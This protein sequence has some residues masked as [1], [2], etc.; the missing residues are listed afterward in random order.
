M[1]GLILAFL[2]VYRVWVYGDSDSADGRQQLS[3]QKRQ[4][5]F[6]AADGTLA[7]RTHSTGGDED[8]DCAYGA[9]CHQANELL[10][11]NTTN[12]V[13]SELTWD[14]DGQQTAM[15]VRWAPPNPLL[16]QRRVD[17]NADNGR[18]RSKAMDDRRAS[19]SATSAASTPLPPS[20]R[21][22]NRRRF[23]QPT[24]ADHRLLS[25]MRDA[26]N[27]TPPGSPSLPHP[28]NRVW[29]AL[30]QSLDLAH[31]PEDHRASFC[32]PEL[33]ETDDADAE[34][35]IDAASYHSNACDATTGSAADH[36]YDQCTIS[37]P[38]QHSTT[39]SPHAAACH[40]LQQESADDDGQPTAYTSHAPQKAGRPGSTLVYEVRHYPDDGRSAHANPQLGQTDDVA[41]PTAASVVPPKDVYSV[42][43]K[44]RKPP[45]PPPPPLSTA[46]AQPFGP[47]TVATS[48]R[49]YI[50]P[51]DAVS[52][53]SS[54][55]LRHDNSAARITAPSACS[56]LVDQTARRHL[57]YTEPADAVG[58]GGGTRSP[59]F[60]LPP[61]QPPLASPQPPQAAQQQHPVYRPVYTPTVDVTAQLKQGLSI[62]TTTP[63]T[64]GQ[65]VARKWANRSTLSPN[66]LRQHGGAR[67]RVKTAIATASRAGRYS[68]APSTEQRQL[69]MQIQSCNHGI[70]ISSGNVNVNGNGNHTPAASTVSQHTASPAFTSY[71]LLVRPSSAASSTNAS[72]T[73]TS[74]L[75]V[76]AP[77]RRMP[78]VMNSSASTSSVA[79]LPAR[80]RSGAYSTLSPHSQ[81]MPTNET[82]HLV[83]ENQKLVAQVQSAKLALENERLRAKLA[84]LKQDARPPPP[85]PPP[86]PPRRSAVGQEVDAIYE[87]ID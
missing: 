20:P 50:E 64:H 8:D 40:A 41:T 42:S 85:P 59:N 2:F 66:S 17:S 65:Q 14:D 28:G 11:D 4:P 38:L 47:T 63:L 67:P 49:L 55:P 70:E 54:S 34:A 53:G 51:A 86:P 27:G 58:G 80:V 68:G 87:S 1:V 45:P 69:L 43:S 52:K 83:N 84:A 33:G 46:A 25:D 26:Q 39:R 12:N 56:S 30:T 74:K 13:D 62:G 29:S 23:D 32:S 22:P 75:A 9:Q 36:V 76:L 19:S 79:A 44:L 48:S 35:E 21:S 5:S 6:G 77:N 82:E 37:S 81:R 10:Y 60:L 57:V 31:C 15:G 73:S 16:A 72:S 78:T 24:A 7:T 3:K 71:S 61:P 18:R